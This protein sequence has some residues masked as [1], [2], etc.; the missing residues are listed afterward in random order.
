[1]RMWSLAAL[2]LIGC[3]ESGELKVGDGT[4]DP[5]LV[6]PLAVELT[7]PQYAQ[8]VGDGPIEVAGVVSR[9]DATVVIGEE[10]VA[11]AEDGSFSASVPIAKG[12]GLVDIVVTSDEETW[13]DRVPVFA[14]RD[15]QESWTGGLSGRL[16]TAGLAGIGDLFAGVIEGFLGED[17]PLQNLP[18]F[19]FSGVELQ[20]TGLSRGDLDVQVIPGDSLP[21]VEILLTELSLDL[22]ISAN[23]GF[24]ITVP[25]SL[26]FNDVGLSAGLELALE[27]EQRDLVA[28]LVEPDLSFGEP[29]LSLGVPGLGWLTDL[30]TNSVNLG[31]LLSGQLGDLLGEGQRFTVIEGPVEFETDLLGQSISLELLDLFT[32]ADGVGLAAG[33][34]LG[35]PVDVDPNALFVPPA[36]EGVDLSLVL[37]DAI[38]QPI[39]ETDLLSA[40]E[41][42][43]VL[44]GAFAA[45]LDGPLSA[46]PGGDDIPDHE[47][48]CLTLDP[49][50]AKLARFQDGLEPMVAIWFP[51]AGLQLG[52]QESAGDECQSW[53][54][55]ALAIEA[56]LVVEEGTKLAVDLNLA[57]PLIQYYGAEVDDP[58]EVADSLVSI[59]GGLLGL[60]GGTLEF[61]LADLLGGAGAGG[62]LPIDISGLSIVGSFAP[63]SGPFE[64]SALVG[65]EL[66]GSPDEVDPAR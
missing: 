31:D 41:Q 59:L 24:P 43:I 44:P 16:G 5:V 7:S 36:I 34:G 1:M 49:G 54:E 50:A 15:P 12:Y 39:L 51:D 33:I 4:E 30:L 26:T 60:V 19:E 58:Q 11:V 18:P 55:L 17:L 2:A 45:I 28:G 22:E 25:A 61:D 27:G 46:L 47:T 56:G 8:F 29:E 38:L 37:H 52:Y 9:N 57:E 48:W 63:T 14:G 42:D 10:T 20:I 66:F 6:E 13:Q 35:G 53:V 3:V 32:D 23:L 64:G 40:L 65:F 62:Q 21:V